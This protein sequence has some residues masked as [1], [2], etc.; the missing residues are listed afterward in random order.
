VRL[1]CGK[2]G[3]RVFSEASVRFLPATI[4][5]PQR[6]LDHNVVVA[7]EAAQHAIDVI[8]ANAFKDDG[9]WKTKSLG[10]LGRALDVQCAHHR[11]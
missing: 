3:E 6:W 8:L 10:E 4:P 9:G 1:S 5:G 7:I 11:R 2:V